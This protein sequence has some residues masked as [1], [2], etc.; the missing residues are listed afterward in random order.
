MKKVNISLI[1]IS[2]KLFG[3][4][5][6]R[7]ERKYEGLRREL[8]RARI[9]ITLQA[10]VSLTYFACF[11]AFVIFLLIGFLITYMIVVIRGLP[12]VIFPVAIPQPLYLLKEYRDTIVMILL[13]P[14]IGFAG[15]LVIYSLFLFYPKMKVSDRR[16]KIDNTLPYAVM[17]LYALSQGGMN[18]LETFRSLSEKVESYGEV[19]R[20]ALM[21]IRD[22]E[23]F[24]K[25]FRTALADCMESTPSS[26]FSEFLHNLLSIIES[27]GN[28][29]AFMKEKAEDYFQKA[30]VKQKEFLSTLELMAESYVT[31]FVAA[32][33]FIIIISSIMNVMGSM[34]LLLLKLLVYLVLPVGGLMFAFIV[35]LIS[36]ENSEDFTL[37]KVE[38]RDEKLEEK[39]K[40][41]EIYKKIVRGRRKIRLKKL[42]R[43]P[44][45][46]FI[47]RPIDTLYISLIPAL[48]LISFSLY[49]FRTYPLNILM[50]YIDDYIFFSILIA[51]LPF[52]IFQEIYMRN[53][54][55]IEEEIPEML[56]RLANINETGMNI[57]QSVEILAN[58]HTGYLREEIVKMW[59]DI[60]LGNSITDVFTR[61]ANRLKIPSV[62]RTVTLITEA[63][64]SSGNIVNVL[65]IAAND[66]Y[67]AVTMKRERKTNMLTYVMIIYI[68]FFVFI[69]IVFILFKYFIPIM[70]EIS[71]SAPGIGFGGGI[72][73]KSGNVDTIKMILFHASMI[74]GFFSGINAGVMGGEGMRG[75]VKH[76][77]IL[78]SFAY[79]LFAI[80]V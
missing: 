24:G 32:P 12:E 45:R 17:Y 41:K 76:S 22:M 3:N 65:N 19:A 63:I 1:S 9:P 2:L 43:N 60:K 23:Y 52:A 59:R 7:R 31:A 6:E 46:Y 37:L 53:R 74:Q 18:I 44:F 34:N 73:L 48:I 64:K 5:A 30:L 47:E 70:F 75:G 38:K 49:S 15:S 42:M 68:A 61:F 40:G 56:R 71:P 11:L 78:T 77:L 55:K 72:S 4:L 29:S 66:A 50:R 8:R 67:N 58:T 35:Q 25:D 26:T 33:L 21:I 16:T 39:L 14:I 28:I 79:A 10:Y 80:F 36:V 51:L 13:P 69:G 54:R 62:T 57:I 20:E 27:G